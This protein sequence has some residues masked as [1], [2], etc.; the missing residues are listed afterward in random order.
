[1]KDVLRIR[2]PGIGPD[3]RR[4][5]DWLLTRTTPARV[6]AVADAIGAPLRSDVLAELIDLVV[7]RRRDGLATW[8][9]RRRTR[10][11]LRPFARYG[12]DPRRAPLCA[13]RAPPQP[14]RPVAT[15]RA[16]DEAGIGGA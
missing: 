16:A 7:Q 6:V 11:A 12:G 2:T 13:R 1:M 9:L 5:I 14:A 10:R 3:F 15:T 4:E 8:S